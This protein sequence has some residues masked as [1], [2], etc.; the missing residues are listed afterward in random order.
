LTPP[1]LCIGI[2]CTIFVTLFFFLCIP[3]L[4]RV[5][6]RVLRS[7]AQV[8]RPWECLCVC[9][10]WAMLQSKLGEKDTQKRKK[11]LCDIDSK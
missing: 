9:V 2:T 5:A 8:S 11:P 7:I 1:N 3:I 10:S 6:F 4:L